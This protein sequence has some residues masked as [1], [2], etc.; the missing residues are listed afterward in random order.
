M[1]VIFEDDLI[2]FWYYFRWWSGKIKFYP[3]NLRLCFNY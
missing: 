2:L 1:V 3:W